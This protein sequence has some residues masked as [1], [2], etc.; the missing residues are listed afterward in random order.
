MIPIRD[1]IATR[2]YPIITVS[3]IFVNILI[4]LWMRFTLTGTE[5]Q[6]VYKYYG[7]VP[8]EYDLS[9]L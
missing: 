1:N 7:L 9:F 3:I 2:T 6:I 8:R 4:F 5:G